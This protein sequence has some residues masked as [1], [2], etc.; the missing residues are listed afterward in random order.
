MK[1]TTKEWALYEA[2]KTYNQTV[3]VQ[4]DMAYYDV[5]DAVIAFYSG[6]QWRNVVGDDLPKPV[7]NYIK[8]GLTFFVASLTSSNIKLQFSNIEGEDDDSIV[9]INSEISNILEKM[10]IENRIREMLF[11]AG[12]VGNSFMHFY[13]DPDIKQYEGE[14]K[15]C[16][17]ILDGSNVMFGNAN[18]SIVEEQPYIIIVGRD[19]A[20]N[21]EE[22]AKYNK[23]T[24]TVEEDID[25]QYMPGD[26]GKIEVE[27]DKYGKALYIIKYYR[28]KKTGR[29]F[30]TKCTKDVY[31]YQDIDLGYDYY[32][33]SA[34]YWDKEKNTYHGKGM[35]IEMIPNQIL[36]NKMFAMVTYH[37]MLSAFPTAIYNAD[38]IS[39]WSNELGAEIALKNLETGESIFNSAGYLAPAQMSNQ[40]IN[41]IDMAIKYTKECM[42]ISDASFGNVDPKNT[43]AIIAVQ[44]SAIIP[45]EN[46]K[47]NLYEC[48]E[49][50]G[51]ILADMTATKYGV[52]KTVMTDEQGN[53]TSV[54][55]DFAQL[56]GKWRD[57]KA[58]VGA[59]GYYSEIA[60][61]QT[62]D[63]LLATEKINILQYFKRLPK[64]LVPNLEGLIKELEEQM[65]MG[66]QEAP[67]DEAT[68]EQMAQ[69][70]YTL[71][72]EIQ[73]EIRKLTD[74]E[75]QT[76]VMQMMANDPDVTGQRNQ[77]EAEG[78]LNQAIGQ[79]V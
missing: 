33:I 13:F 74:K 8:R 62:L 72:P 39:E 9:V 47:A 21:L 44:K 37:L 7:F 42:G 15:I 70:I 78:N 29:I 10:K 68:M 3:K 58:D 38:K 66:E 65:G 23:N 71:P 56:K 60:S 32:P 76:T 61:L 22:E 11:D 59:S 55:Y 36:I 19:L 52:R 31:I 20:K 25:Y 1:D 27:A 35:V 2:G 49:D 54:E 69:Y 77:M 4:G 40:I 45:L 50:T 17:E 53:K 48:M 79:I 73:V 67:L 64:N 5:I 51:R 46:V 14:G 34:L 12:I 28:D 57:V 75:M 16:H 24:V 26:N 18:N 6:D 63:N 30:A 43:S 41:A